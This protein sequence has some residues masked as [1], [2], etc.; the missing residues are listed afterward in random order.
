MAHT[1]DTKASTETI[2]IDLGNGVTLELKLRHGRYAGIAAARLDGDSFL[3]NGRGTVPYCATPDGIVYTDFAFRELRKRDG[4]TVVSFAALGRVQPVTQDPDMFLFPKLSGNLLEQDAEDTLEIIL[5]PREAVVDGEA[6]RGFAIA[7]EFR[8]EKRRI[9][10]LLESVA[11]APKGELRDATVISQHLTNNLCRLE[12]TVT[13]DSLYNTE[14]NYDITCIQA[15]CRGGG[16][17]IFEIVQDGEL[18]VVTFFAKP[19]ALKAV[20][21]S[22]PGEEFVTVADFHYGTLASTFTTQPRIVLAAHTGSAASREARVNRW[23]AWFD[24]T[25]ALWRKELGIRPTP[26]LPILAMDGTGGGGVDPGF[27]YPDLLLAWEQRLAWVK[28]QGFGAIILHTPEWVSAANR[29][30][31]VMG[32][33][34]CCP[35]EYKLSDH[36]G[37]EAG[38]KRFC[39]AAH[40]HGIQVYVWI[41]GHLAAESPV[42][43]RHPEWAV[44]NV[45]NL[46][47]D[48]HYHVIHALSFTHSAARA[49]LLADLLHL[50]TTTGVDGVWYDSFTNLSLQAIN[51][52]STGREPNAPAVLEFLGELSRAGFD[53]QFECL[54]QL[55]VSS[56][57]NLKP[58]KITGQEELLYNTGLRTYLDDWLVQPEYTRD[59]YFRCLAARAP[60]N[61]WIKEY[62]GRPT[63]FPLRLP[64]WYAPLTRAYNQVAPDMHRRRL[65]P[66]GAGALWYDVQKRPAAFFAFRDGPAPVTGPMRDLLADQPATGTVEAGHI[67]AIVTPVAQ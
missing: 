39:D 12:E 51:Y 48:G 7:Y 18:A 16:S 14:E 55:G 54:S 40:R 56:W 28:E 62:M 37:G 29:R 30:T 6:Y 24:Y 64:D 33:N 38:M 34:N 42:W 23:T 9:H 63:P 65:L 49:W 46:V 50:R 26:A 19:G 11:I 59:Y 36:L 22:L 25:G 43:R 1:N 17:Q 13:R 2:P 31:A 32:G 20:I 57:G 4:A 5:E 10:W 35:F 27:T 47:W 21:Q 60:L 44:R 3:V 53:L 15:P 52:Q 41:S 61:V 58:A 8:S 67:Y 45:G 66:D